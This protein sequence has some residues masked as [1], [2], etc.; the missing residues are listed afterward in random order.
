MIWR[1]TGL[2]L[3][4]TTD[5]VIWRTDQ[6]SQPP[7]NCDL[8]KNHSNLELF[9]EMPMYVT[10]V[11]GIH[12]KLSLSEHSLYLFA[13]FLSALDPGQPLAY[14]QSLHLLNLDFSFPIHSFVP[15]SQGLYRNWEC[16]SKKTQ[17]WEKKPLLGVKKDNPQKNKTI[18]MRS[19]T[20][21]SVWNW[22]HYNKGIWLVGEQEVMCGTNQVKKVKKFPGRGKGLLQKSWWWREP[23]KY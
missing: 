14:F 18:A 22:E 1:I 3:F 12:Y 20:N 7:E 6:F 5:L 2:V 23:R 4:L 21:R 13:R 19:A 17:P 8:R 9:K 16:T 10:L 15:P 11:Q